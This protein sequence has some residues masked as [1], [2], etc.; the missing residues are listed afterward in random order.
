VVGGEAQALRIGEQLPAQWWQLF[1]S[2]KL[3]ALVQQA[4]AN[5]PSVLSARASLTQAQE[6]LRAQHG[7]LVPSFDV[8]LGATR[9]K[10]FMNF[11]EPGVIGPM[12]LYNSSIDVGYGLDIFGGLRRVV[13]AQGAQV[14]FQRYELQATYLTLASN[15]VT[16]AVQEA[17]LR[18][19]LEAMQSMIVAQEERLRLTEKQF[20]FGAVPYADLPSARSALATLRSQ[21]PPVQQNLAAVQSQLAVYVGKLP[22]EWQNTDFA[23]DQLL[24]PQNVPLGV[25]SELV[26]RRPDVLAAEAMLHR[27]SAEVGVA[28]ANLFPKLTLTGSYGGQ[29]DRFSNLFDNPVWSIGANL[30][31]PLFHGGT[32]TAQRR[33]ALAAF[34]VASHDY[35]ETVLNAFKNVADALQ[36]VVTDAEALQSQ[37][38]ALTAAEESLQLTEQQ[39]RLGGV[40]YVGLLIAQRQ[41]QQARIDY[42]QRLAS[43]Y[44]DTA[45]LMHAL[46]GG[47]SAAEDPGASAA[48]KPNTTSNNTAAAQPAA[49]QE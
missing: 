37:Q 40:G 23:L 27:A 17:S 39:Y 6:I 30:T 4:F 3:D 41:A 8:G 20:E 42:V 15:V 29:S 1:G 2:P 14:D 13:E 44:Q 46:G 43:R 10:S 25:P 26:R 33:A 7:A 9:Q 28:T 21:L 32:L 45:A 36:A 11:G 19:Q 35:R 48:N 22:A 24:L 5:N 18:A 34:D 47:W 12:N 49:E 31:Q 38:V 16:A